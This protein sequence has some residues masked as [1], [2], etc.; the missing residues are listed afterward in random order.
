PWGWDATNEYWYDDGAGL[1]G[2]GS[3]TETLLGSAAA[4]GI[5]AASSQLLRMALT[6]SDGSG[7]SGTPST[8]TSGTPST[9][10][11]GAASDTENR[12]AYHE[13]VPVMRLDVS[14]V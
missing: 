12:P 14:Y 7:T 3:Q 13:L 11:S 5:P 6:R 10:T 2:Y 4:H 8:N 1:P 9:N